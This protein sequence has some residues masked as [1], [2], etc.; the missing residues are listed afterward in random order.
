M[1]IKILYL[2]DSPF[3]FLPFTI[4]FSYINSLT[5]A[6]IA[7]GVDWSTQPNPIVFHAINF[8]DHYCVQHKL[9]HNITETLRFALTIPS[10]LIYCLVSKDKCSA[11]SLSLL[12]PSIFIY[13]SSTFFLHLHHNSL[14]CAPAPPPSS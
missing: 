9:G 7:P 1:V 5:V 11:P 13:H 6:F 2:M 12:S 14:S 8:C 3:H 10:V 4:P